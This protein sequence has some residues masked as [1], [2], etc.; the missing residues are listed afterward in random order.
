[1]INKRV[2]SVEEFIFL[3]D[4][5]RP[6]VPLSDDIYIVST[7]LIDQ[8][9]RFGVA[10]SFKGNQHYEK[11]SAR[12]K[13]QLVFAVL[14]KYYDRLFFFFNDIQAQ[15]QSEHNFIRRLLTTLDCRILE[16]GQQI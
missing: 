6:H 11:M 8:S 10:K 15:H 3:I 2:K 12:L 5:L 7:S 1:M 16:S 13:N 9:Y 4:R 14:E